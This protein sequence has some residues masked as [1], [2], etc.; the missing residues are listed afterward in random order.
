MLAPPSVWPA[1]APHDLI[2]PAGR[3]LFFAA[4]GAGCGVDDIAQIPVAKI[5]WNFLPPMSLLIKFLFHSAALFFR[6]VMHGWH[7]VPLIIVH[8]ATILVACPQ[9][10]PTIQR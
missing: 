8:S 2:E 10:G 5:C 1:F 9:P 6:I 3:L 7:V 4:P